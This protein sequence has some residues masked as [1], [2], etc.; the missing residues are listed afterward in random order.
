MAPGR[1]QASTDFQSPVDSFNVF[2][3]YQSMVPT[4][5]ALSCW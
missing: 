1:F 5:N 2:K 3:M 4:P